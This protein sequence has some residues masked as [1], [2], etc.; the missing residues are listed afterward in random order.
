MP[1]SDLTPF[2]EPAGVAVIGASANPHKLSHGILRNLI[3][4]TYSGGV[5]PVNPSAEE[6]LGKPCYTDITAVPDPVELAVLVIPARATP[7]TLEACGQR[8]IHV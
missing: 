3:N 1:V 7:Q 8:G 4:S 6:I 2:F 5:Y